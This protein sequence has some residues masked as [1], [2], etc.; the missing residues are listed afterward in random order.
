MFLILN[1]FKSKKDP[2][3]EQTPSR[4]KRNQE[5][6]ANRKGELGEYKIDIQLDQLPEDY[7]YLSDLLI[8]NPKAKSGYSQVDHVI[9]TPHGLFVIETKNYQGTI[10]GG[11]NRKT[12]SVNGKFKMMNPFTQNYGHMKAL[13]ALIDTKYQKSFISIVSFTK[14]CTFKVEP[15]LRQISSNQLIVYDI[16]LSEYIHRK[17]RALKREPQLTLSK[18]EQENIKAAFQLAN[19]TDPKIWQAHKEALKKPSTNEKATCIVCSK[20][21]S[22]KVKAYC[23]SQKKF[24]GKIY[25]Y[26][27]Q[28]K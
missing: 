10:Y 9:I 16:E 24:N 1:L 2:K 27:H 6:V 18:E 26:E 17:V 12:W 19:I 8:K 4:P 21:V 3:K 15:E 28:K 14:R 22:E 23:L 7:Y 5:Q 25:C 11:K 13:A 20:A